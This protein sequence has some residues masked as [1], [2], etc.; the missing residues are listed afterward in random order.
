MN[1]N[2]GNFRDAE[3]YTLQEALTGAVGLLSGALTFAGG[4]DLAPLGPPTLVPAPDQEEYPG[5]Y[6]V[7]I[8]MGTTTD[9]RQMYVWIDEEG[10]MVMQA[11]CVH[12]LPAKRTRS[13]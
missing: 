1:I 13:E 8:P 7:W 9:D 5:A 6:Q 10:Q 4:E 2:T 11:M 3:G 12:P